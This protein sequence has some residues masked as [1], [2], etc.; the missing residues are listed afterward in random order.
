MAIGGAY[1]L[2]IVITAAYDYRRVKAFRE[3]ADER[4]D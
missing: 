4:D 1:C 3:A 2:L